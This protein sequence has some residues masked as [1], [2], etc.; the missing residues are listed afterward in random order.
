MA[1][2]EVLLQLNP[3]IDEYQ[4]YYAQSLYKAGRYPEAMR[5]AVR[6]DYPMYTQR[7]L[8]LQSAIKYAMEELPACKAL[9]DQCGEDEPETLINHA[10]IAFKE[11]GCRMTG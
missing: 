8:L 10:A 5:A 4:V 2:Y 7:M 11:V 3:S 9:L 6:L 1:C